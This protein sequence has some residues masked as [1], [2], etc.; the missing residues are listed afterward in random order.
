MHTWFPFVRI[1]AISGLIALVGYGAVNA[2]TLS[3][4][5]SY[6]SNPAAGNTFVS[7]GTRISRLDAITGRAVR[8]VLERPP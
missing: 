3:A 4:D 6:G 8:L 5:I 7:N 2:T 1:V